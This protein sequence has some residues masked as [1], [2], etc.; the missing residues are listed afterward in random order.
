MHIAKSL[1]F[2]IELWLQLYHVLGS[3]YIKDNSI[4]VQFYRLI[5]ISG[6]GVGNSLQFAPFKF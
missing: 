2:V 5:Y 1:V 6:L 3:D 4:S